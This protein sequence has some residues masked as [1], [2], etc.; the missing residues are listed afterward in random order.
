MG[1][2]SYTVGRVFRLLV[3]VRKQRGRVCEVLIQHMRQPK[4]MSERSIARQSNEALL[5][6]GRAAAVA[7][8]NADCAGAE[9]DEERDEGAEDEPVGVPPGDVEAAVTRTVARGAEEHHLDHPCDE[10]GEQREG[11]DEGHEDGA[12]T[13]VRRAAQAEEEGNARETGG[14]GGR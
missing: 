8:A 10:R 5:D 1:E 14:C 12:G 6:G 2:D 9:A 4:G 7:T 13:V 3:E 11:G